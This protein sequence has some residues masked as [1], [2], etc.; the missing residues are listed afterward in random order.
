MSKQLNKN[1]KRMKMKSPKV[2]KQLMKKDSLAVKMT[3]HNNRNYSP[4]SSAL[5]SILQ[6]IS[7]HKVMRVLLM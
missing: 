2:G 7:L 1:I 4:W 5:L 3:H 6:L